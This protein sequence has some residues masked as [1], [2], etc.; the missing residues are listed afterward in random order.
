MIYTETGDLDNGFSHTE[1]TLFDPLR[2]EAAEA[3]KS[4]CASDSNCIPRRG[5]LLAAFFTGERR[6]RFEKRLSNL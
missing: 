6:F 1:V 4:F 5:N 3:L 2:V